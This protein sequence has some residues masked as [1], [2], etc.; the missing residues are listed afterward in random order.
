MLVRPSS[1]DPLLEMTAVAELS[2]RA[3][4][5]PNPPLDGLLE[6]NGRDRILA[7]GDLR[8]P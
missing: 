2:L 6:D 5:I 1:A 3:G 7:S 8:S 4:A